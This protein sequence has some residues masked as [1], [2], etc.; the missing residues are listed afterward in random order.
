VREATAF[1]RVP[2]R[3]H[4]QIPARLVGRQTCYYDRVVGLVNGRAIFV[5][6][7]S[8]ARHRSVGSRCCSGTACRTR[9]STGCATGTTLRD[10]LRPSSVSFTRV[11]SSRQSRRSRRSRSGASRTPMKG[12]PSYSPQNIEAAKLMVSA[13]TA[14]LKKNEMMACSVASRRRGF[15]KMDTSEVC[16]AAP[17]EVAK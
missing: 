17:N 14:V 6:G 8:L 1:L 15:V 4:A 2:C 10:T 16:E 9:S 7:C 11:R 5:K 3:A 12:C 13:N